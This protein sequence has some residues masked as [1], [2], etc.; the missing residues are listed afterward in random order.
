MEWRDVV[1]EFIVSKYHESRY[2]RTWL[3][4]MEEKCVVLSERYKVL[5]ELKKRSIDELEVII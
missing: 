2:D 4:L 5:K 1:R 3:S